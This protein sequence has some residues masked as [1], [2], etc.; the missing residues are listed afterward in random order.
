MPL[1]LVI[2]ALE[3]APD[4]PMTSAITTREPAPIEQRLP[5]A[6]RTARATIDR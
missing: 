4:D 1:G 3:I 2:E 5:T 6:A